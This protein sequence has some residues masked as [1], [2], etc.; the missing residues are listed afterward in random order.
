MLDNDTIKD[1]YGKKNNYQNDCTMTVSKIT[2]SDVQD[3]FAVANNGTKD[4]TMTNV[5]LK[6]TFKVT[7]KW[8]SGYSISVD[9][10]A[11]E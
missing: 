6:D 3:T 8:S 4:I 7:F 1:Q 11:G 9:V 5:N 10:I 2:D